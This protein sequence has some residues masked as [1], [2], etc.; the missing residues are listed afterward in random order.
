VGISDRKV[1][2]NIVSKCPTVA[3]LVLLPGLMVPVLKPP[4]LPVQTEPVLRPVPS[5]AV[6]VEEPLT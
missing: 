5:E 6:E 3:V 2:S 4:P 1:V